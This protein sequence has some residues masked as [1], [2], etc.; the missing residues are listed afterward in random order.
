VDPND[1]IYSRNF[2]SSSLD[3][4]PIVI[5]EYKLIFFTVPTAARTTWKQLFRRMKGLDDWRKEG[6]LIPHDPEANGLTFLC[7]YPIEDANRIMT[8][9][10]AIPAPYS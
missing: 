5:E 7:D 1:Y 6:T 4:A 10:Q 8:D 2:T 3:T 9:P